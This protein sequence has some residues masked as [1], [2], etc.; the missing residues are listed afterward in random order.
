[1]EQSRSSVDVPLPFTSCH[2]VQVS[3]L[4]AN[5]YSFS[6]PLLWLENRSLSRRN[7]D[8][9][10]KL[11]RG[12]RRKGGGAKAPFCSHTWHLNKINLQERR[13]MLTQG[14][15]MW[16]TARAGR[17]GTR[18]RGRGRKREGGEC[19]PATK[20][21]E[22]VGRNGS[23]RRF[24]PFANQIAIIDGN[25]H[26]V[27]TISLSPLLVWFLPLAIPLRSS[28]L[29]PV[30]MLTIFFSV[31]TAP[32][33][34]PLTII[35]PLIHLSDT[36]VTSTADF[37][38]FFRFPAVSF[39]FSLSFSVSLFRARGVRRCVNFSRQQFDNYNS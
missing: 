13:Q 31:N 35:I 38:G 12:W 10:I 8:N 14:I 7:R 32:P 19:S 18:G 27:E 22:I 2:Q 26:T 21:R 30:E 33:S 11:A 15:S 29:S 9:A 5:T 3:F 17:V 36:T 20:W 28:D 16:L 24:E 34:P 25:N 23:A 4:H 6:F 1:M 39:F 37:P